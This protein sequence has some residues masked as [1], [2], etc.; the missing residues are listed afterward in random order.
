LN[1]LSILCFFVLFF[2]PEL[3]VV[4]ILKDKIFAWI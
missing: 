1:Y 3:E 4:S 2:S